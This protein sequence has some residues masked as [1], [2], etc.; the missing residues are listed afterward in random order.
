MTKGHENLYDPI[1]NGFA[2]VSS[3]WQ[4]SDCGVCQYHPVAKSAI[5]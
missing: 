1:D 5:T 3:A 4:L 2:N